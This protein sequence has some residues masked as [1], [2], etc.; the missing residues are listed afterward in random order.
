MKRQARETREGNRSMTKQKDLYVS[1]GAF[2][3]KLSMRRFKS[4]AARQPF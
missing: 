1:A 2:S 3:T 4:N